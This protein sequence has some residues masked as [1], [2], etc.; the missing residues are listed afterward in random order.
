MALSIST[1]ITVPKPRFYINTVSRRGLKDSPPYL[2]DGRRLTLVDTVEVFKL[3]LGLQLNAQ[4]KNA[5][6]AFMRQ[7]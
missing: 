1:R 7:L 5:L 4:E 3:V 6:V 2:H